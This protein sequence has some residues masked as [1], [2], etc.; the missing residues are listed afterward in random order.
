MIS[1]IMLEAWLV[2]FFTLAI[3]SF[4]IDDNPI[5]KAAEHLFAGASA[6]YGVVVAYWE[7]IRPNL[8]GK[9]WPQ[10]DKLDQESL[11]IDI[12]YSIYDIMY[13]I[14]TLFG[15][16][17][18]ILLTK[19][20]ISTSIYNETSVISFSFIIPLILGLLM[21]TR[22]IPKLSWL[23]R[24]SIAYI[25]GVFAGL[26]AFNMVQSDI[27]LQ[28]KG[29]TELVIYV[30]NEINIF[31]I[32][33]NLILV[34]GTIC[35]LF[36]FFFSKQHDGI[37]GKISKV[38]IWTLMISFGGAFGYTVMARISLLIG[39]FDKLIEFSDSK[40]NYASFWCLVIIVVTLLVYFIVKRKN[41]T[42]FKNT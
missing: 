20:G 40:Y 21:L 35:A 15:L 5:Y 1:S 11:L 22:L 14:T 30:D 25:V 28:V 9:L 27:V 4:L 7:Y 31:L 19:S 10:K 42:K 33:S 38:G 16:I 17:D 24:Y 18:P 2:A 23:A 37:M 29:F 34:V 8:L 26:R 3:L 36:Y 12:W 39:R 41:K 6:G 13:E 32:V